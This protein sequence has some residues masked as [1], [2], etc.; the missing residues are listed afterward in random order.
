MEQ[1]ERDQQGR[2]PRGVSGNPSGRPAG[3]RN[4]MTL[5]VQSA[6]E[7]NAAALI[8][9]TIA[10]ALEGDPTALRLCIDRLLPPCKDR[11]IHL[12]LPA[13]AADEPILETSGN[14]LA[15]VAAGEIT[16]S[17]GEALAKILT[18][19]SQIVSIEDMDR[20]LKQLEE[21]IRS[22]RAGDVDKAA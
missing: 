8:S 4:K 21:R 14:V 20:R 1:D 5:L 7:D 6:L 17:E 12:D 3:S 16:P 13:D 15:A 10:L 22:E 11:P 18:A 19:H 9:K 2:W